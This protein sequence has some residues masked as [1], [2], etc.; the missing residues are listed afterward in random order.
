MLTLHLTGYSFKKLHLYNIIFNF[1]LSKK[2]FSEIVVLIFIMY[3]TKTGP[4][5]FNILFQFHSNFAS[6]LLLKGCLRL[7]LHLPFTSDPEEEPPFD[8]CRQT[9]VP[10]VSSST[11]RYDSMSDDGGNTF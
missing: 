11:A 3:T 10:D 1:I 6:Y 4:L 2:Y 8:V 9:S 5:D 7:E